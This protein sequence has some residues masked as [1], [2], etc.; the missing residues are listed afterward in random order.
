MLLAVIGKSNRENM[1]GSQVMESELKKLVSINSWSI[2]IQLI[3]LVA[4][5]SF[6]AVLYQDFGDV[7][8]TI[9][10]VS[11]PNGGPAV[12]DRVDDW[13]SFIRPH[14]FVTGDR[15]SDVVVIEF[16]DFQC[17]YCK[18]FNEGSRKQI[19]E[20]YGDQV[21]WVF[22]HYPLEGIHPEA[23]NA[24]VAAQCAL[25]GNSFLPAKDALFENS[26][27]LSKDLYAEIGGNLG[28]GEEYADCI[29][30]QES[31]AEVEQ[32]IRDAERAGLGGTPTFLVNGKVEMGAIT[33][34][35][36]ESIIQSA[37]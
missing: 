26:K 19:S 32:D 16:T 10:S 15:G 23:K 6:S 30:N 31:L 20:K 35:R 13:M 1:E 29:A 21:L 33:L 27:V 18:A 36:F 11:V 25:R 2:A 9:A 28:L 8:R 14:N 7:K 22:K 34:A 4:I 17:P 24:A 37:L 12:P 5:V 3:T